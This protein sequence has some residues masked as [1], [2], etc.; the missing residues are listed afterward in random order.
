[1]EAFNTPNSGMPSKNKWLFLALLS[2]VITTL[3]ILLSTD[4]FERAWVRSLLIAF[5]FIVATGSILFWVWRNQSLAKAENEK[6]FKQL[7]AYQSVIDYLKPRLPLPAMRSWAVSP[8]LAQYLIEHIDQY[9]PKVILE[10]GCGVSTL[11]NAY[12]CEKNGRGKVISID[13]EAE[14]AK[15]FEEKVVRHGLGEHSDI[16]VSDFKNFDFS[17]GKWKWYD[18]DFDALP[19]IDLLFVDAPYYHLQS[20][21]RY[22]AL[23]LLADKIQPGGFVLLDDASRK[24]IRWVLNEWKKEFPK[25]KVT[26]IDCEKGA[27]ILQKPL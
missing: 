12:C 20:N 22:P 11:V 25:W 16:I 3:A 8:D 15:T 9:K 10:I 14:Y 23:P 18:I 27:C 1:M 4:L 7:S 17:G 24:D 6:T 26:W 2:G 19:M 13:S 5:M 21:A